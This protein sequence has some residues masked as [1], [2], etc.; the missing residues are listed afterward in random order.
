M[1]SRFSYIVS[2]LLIFSAANAFAQEQFLCVWRNPE[3]TMNKIFSDAN[4]YRTVNLSISSQQRKE[5]EKKLGSELLPGQQE[6]LSV[7]E[8]TDRAGEKI[9]TI[10]AVTQ[11]G[12]F[13][14]V[15]FVFGLDLEGKIRGMYI[16]RARERD[17]EFKK[18][19]F[20]DSF[21]GKALADVEE[22]APKFK[23]ASIAVRAV[24]LGVRKELIAYNYLTN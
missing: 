24:I 14:A 9:G 4:D 10:M 12:E 13:G 11:K 16:Q 1:K 19:E 23:E 18:R 22:M 7:F 6:N 21:K 3:R 15:E 5:I 2:F 8:M 17:K 20:L